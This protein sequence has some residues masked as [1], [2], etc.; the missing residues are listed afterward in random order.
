MRGYNK[1][2][3][4]SYILEMDR[5]FKENENKSKDCVNRLQERISELEAENSLLTEQLKSSQFKAEP[6][7]ESIEKEDELKPD[8]K[9]CENYSCNI[10]SIENKNTY[11]KLKSELYDKISAQVGNI[12]INAAKNADDIVRQAEKKA[13]KIVENADDKAEANIDRLTEIMRSLTFEVIQS[14]N[15]NIEN[16][17]KDFYTYVEDAACSSKSLSNELERKYQDMQNKISFYHESLK[18]GVDNS[19]KRLYEASQKIDNSKYEII[20]QNLQ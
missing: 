2:D 8:E 3:V 13:K 1:V 16:F 10:S 4:N 12:L 20:N 7:L 15:E 17:V 5:R 18:E 6:S 19:I 14:T 9:K 11:D